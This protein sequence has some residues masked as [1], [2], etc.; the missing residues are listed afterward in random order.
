MEWLKDTSVI[1]QFSIGCFIAIVF[2]QSGIDKVVDWKG[3]HSWLTG[4]FKN[5][6]L[7]SLITPML[8]VVTIFEVAAGVVALCGLVCLFWCQDAS[9]IYYALIIGLLSLLMLLFG[10]RIAK[11]YDGA[12]TIAIYIGVLLIGLIFF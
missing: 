11:D 7:S 10:Q 4:H 12:K 2:L 9:C 8:A 3:N 6:F 5:T 1:G